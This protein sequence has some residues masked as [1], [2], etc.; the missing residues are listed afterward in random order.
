MLSTRLLVRLRPQGRRFWPYDLPAFTADFSIGSYIFFSTSSLSAFAGL[1]LK[2]NVMEF[3]DVGLRALF[4]R[5]DL[6]GL[7]VAGRG[8]WQ[9]GIVT[10][11][12]HT[13]LLHSQKF[14]FEGSGAILI[15]P[16]SGSN[17]KKMQQ[18]ISF[19]FLLSRLWLA[20]LWGHCHDLYRT[21]VRHKFGRQLSIWSNEQPPCSIEIRSVF[22][23]MEHA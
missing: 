23:E 17:R 4:K 16:K 11:L 18:Q 2:W 19:W 22:S 3:Q 6:S 21:E 20:I 13:E 1:R 12:T 10:G 8:L 5:C 15:V 7:T 14:R 9:L